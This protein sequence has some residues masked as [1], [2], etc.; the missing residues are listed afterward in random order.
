MKSA[1]LVIDNNKKECNSTNIDI[2]KVNINNDM[3]NNNF[4]KKGNIII[5]KNNK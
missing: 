4:A 1:V 2:N 5:Q 3:F